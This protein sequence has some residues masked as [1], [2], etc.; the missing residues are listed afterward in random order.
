MDIERDDFGKPFAQVLFELPQNQW[1]V[2]IES[3]LGIRY[4]R[5][6]ETHDPELPAFEDM[7]PYLCMDCL[8][9]KGRESQQSKIDELRKNYEIILD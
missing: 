7:E 5:V 1:R 9:E 3:S 8:L 4:G 2:P 6:T